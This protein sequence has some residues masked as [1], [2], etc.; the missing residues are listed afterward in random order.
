[1][2][3]SKCCDELTRRHRRSRRS[4]AEP[5]LKLCG[6]SGGIFS[7]VHPGFAAPIVTP[8]FRSKTVHRKSTIF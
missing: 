3:P 6:G 1:M 4:G 2:L 8:V 5:V 7:G